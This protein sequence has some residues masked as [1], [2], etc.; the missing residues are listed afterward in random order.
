VAQ[1]LTGRPALALRCVTVI[2][3]DIV[4]VDAVATAALAMGDEASAWLQRR[5]G[6]DAVVVAA[7]GSL[8]DSRSSAACSEVT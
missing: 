3:A 4:M 6:Y 7:D 1:V 2:G 5:S 8:C